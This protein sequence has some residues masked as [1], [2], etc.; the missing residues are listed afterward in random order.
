MNTPITKKIFS[1][2]ELHQKKLHLLLPR[3]FTKKK[4]APVAIS[5]VYTMQL[6]SL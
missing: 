4:N 1:T 2:Q 5:F 6:I 3:N